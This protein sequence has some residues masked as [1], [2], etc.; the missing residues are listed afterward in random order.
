M[1]LADGDFPYEVQVAFLLYSM[2]SDRWEGM[3]GIYLGKDWNSLEVLFNIY[4]IHKDRSI[5]LY[6]MK[7][8]EIHHIEAAETKRKAREKR[9]SRKNG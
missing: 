8:N 5:I 9:E 3:N 1:P 6:F 2:L 7:I 4:E